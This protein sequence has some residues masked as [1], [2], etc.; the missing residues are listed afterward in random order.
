MGLSLS[1]VSFHSIFG[2]ESA[3]IPQPA[4]KCEEAHFFSGRNRQLYR[5]LQKSVPLLHKAVRFEW[6]RRILRCPKASSIQQDRRTI[7][8]RS[9][10]A[11]EYNALPFLVENHQQQG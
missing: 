2:S 7:R 8:V 4:K 1:F 11:A 10:Q 3:T 9:V 5:S 6:L